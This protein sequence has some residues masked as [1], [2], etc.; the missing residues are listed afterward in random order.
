MYKIVYCHKGDS[1]EHVLYIP[2]DDEYCLTSG[3]L[4]LELGKAGTLTISVPAVNPARTEVECLTDEIIVYRYWNALTDSELFR[5]RCV[6]RQSDFN[7]TGT[8]VVEGILAYLYDTYYP[9]FKYQG[10]PSNLLYA[11]IENHNSFVDGDRKIYVNRITVTDPNNYIAR[12][13]ESY[14][15]TIDILTDKFCNSSLGGYFSAYYSHGKRYLEYLENSGRTATQK[16]KFGKNLLDIASEVE[17]SNLITAILP[18]GEKTIGTDADGNQT[19]S[20]VTVESVNEGDVY[21]RDTA[22]IEKY[23]FIC[24]C[25]EWEDVT[26]PINLKTKALSYLAQN[27][28][29]IETLTVKAVDLFNTEEY[30]DNRPFGLGQEVTVESEPHGI[31]LSIQLSAMELDML[32][33]ANDSYTFGATGTSLTAASSSTNRDVSETLDSLGVTIGKISA[34]YITSKNISAE[35]AKLGYAKIDDLEAEIGK[36]GY[37]K[38]TDVETEYAK[39]KDLNVVKG[40]VETLTADNAT[41]NGKLTVQEADINSLKAKDIELDGKLTAQDASIAALDAQKLDAESAKITYANIDFSN[42]G[43][44]A[45][46]YFYA[47]SGLIKDITVGDQTITGELVGVTIKGDLIEG[48]T[49]VADKLVI[50]GNDGLYYKLNT[51][52]ATVEKEQTDY[53]SLKGSILQAKSITADKISVKDLVAFDATIGGVN[54]GDSSIYSGTKT[55]VLNTTRGFYLGK[56]GQIAFG[57]ANNYLKYFKDADG[58]WKLMV[59]AGSI[60]FSSGKNIED[61]I[62]DMQERMG[63]IE[64]EV[65][66]LLYISSSQ[67]N[68]FKNTNVS[69]VFSVTIFRGTQRITDSRTMK[70]EFGDGAYL[71]WKYQT[72]DSDEYLMVPPED[73]R[74]LDDGFKFK[75][76]PNDIDTKGIYTCD[77][78][79]E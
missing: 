68:V 74:I 3:K 38:A 17:Y 46:E 44:A 53:N 36:F 63:E 15:R 27:V 47:Q 35:V 52:G 20:Y 77:L 21:I 49:I 66:T 32:S 33:P 29:G 9:P 67:G 30:A 11:V 40:N 4:S 10:S 56:D 5:G 45:M 50:K 69:T 34:D 1:E 24:A 8:L 73:E 39:I 22:M 75:V 23:G 54:I 79:V 65:T 59:S 19:C 71:Q 60:S 6:T 25:V 31:E 41:I 43:K 57:D 78:I 28:I 13:S 18:L 61:T 14:N 2:G 55:S 64:D 51:D 16:I 37:I 72:K 26:E 42:I 62:N 48:N 7:L 58:S 70:T 12:S 76:S